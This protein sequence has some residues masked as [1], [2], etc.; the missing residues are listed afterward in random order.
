LYVQAI[1]WARGGR[2]VC[3]YCNGIRHRR[4]GCYYTLSF[5]LTLPHSWDVVHVAHC[6]P[7]SYTDLQRS[8]AALQLSQGPPGRWLRREALCSSLAGNAVDVLTITAAVGDRGAVPLEQRRG[9][10]LSGESAAAQ[11]G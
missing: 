11:A 4:H 5:A 3:Y 2:G 6:Y 8:L 1:G 10:V 7:Y 9:V